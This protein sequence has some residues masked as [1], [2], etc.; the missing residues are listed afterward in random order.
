MILEAGPDAPDEARIN[1]PGLKGSTLGTQYDWNFTT[2]PQIHA[3]NRKWSQSRG[4]VLGGSSALN[5]MT[6]DRA[7]KHEYDGWERFGNKGWNWNSMIRAM[8]KVEDFLPSKEYGKTGV[9][10]GG[11]IQTLINRFIPAQQEYFIPAM[12]NL[13]IEHN[14]ESL[15]GNPLGVMFQP[16]NI[17]H[18]DYRRS[19]SAHNPGYDSVA[20]SNLHI[21]TDSRVKKINLVR[22]HGELVAIGVTLEDNSTI[23]ASRETIIS[24][25]SLQ[26]PGLLELSGIGSEEVLSAAGIPC[27]LNLPGVGE[28]LQDHLRIE[29]SYQLLP[30]Y[31]SFDILKYN[32]TFVSEQMDMYSSNATSIYDYTG[33]GYSFLNWGQIVAD[34]SNLKSLAQLAA[35]S[36][37]TSSP[38]E[39]I[40]AQR[41]L[42]YLNNREKNVPQVEIVFSDGYTG[43]K[44]YPLANSPLFGSGFFTLIAAVQHPF[45]LGSVHVTSLSI[46][47]APEINPNYLAQEY[48]VQAAIT[49]AKYLRKIANTP[50]LSQAW[51]AE[52]EP[53]L[54]VVGTGADADAQWRD[55]VINN[56]LTIYHPIGTCAMLPQNQNGV[57]DSNL[58]VYGTKNLRVVDGSVIPILMSAHPQTLIYGIAEIAAEK[59]VQLWK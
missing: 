8:L 46:S 56:T 19:Y 20:G 14:L 49:A 27:L 17:R 29:N 58:K 7:S 38:F 37:I 18:D 39:P 51:S 2:V 1:V 13:G 41:L 35:N 5:L 32:A 34:D 10:K 3:G 23:D 16:S 45:S 4:K 31:T 11:P 59:I 36:P 47:T 52:Y 48:D 53:G 30:N 42:E 21:R 54:D 24:A 12:Q 6:W 43:V 57:I 44:G 15:G 33:S 22:E 40:R 55:Y 28:N 50:P 26:S 25:G 9:S